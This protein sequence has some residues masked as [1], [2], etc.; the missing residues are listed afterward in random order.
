M[1][2]IVGYMNEQTTEDALQFLEDWYNH[3][4]YHGSRHAD[5]LGNMDEVLCFLRWRTEGKP[6]VTWLPLPNEYKQALESLP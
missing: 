6:V 2:S 1:D 3:M 4:H 5:D